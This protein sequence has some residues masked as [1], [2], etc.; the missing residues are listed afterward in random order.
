MF[1][2]DILHWWYGAGW[3]SRIQ[4]LKERLAL[5]V[6]FFSIE[7][8]LSTLFS[9]YRQISASTINGSIPE[10]LRSYIDKLISCAI[11]AIVRSFM[12]I[13]GLIAICVCLIT[14]LLM[15][16]VWLIFPIAPIIG[17]ILTILDRNIMWL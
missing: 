15:L 13:V 2:A 9:P 14:N 16:G 17:L 8:L 12:I 6:D 5:M 3:I 10:V 4:S 11:G 1:L 7:L